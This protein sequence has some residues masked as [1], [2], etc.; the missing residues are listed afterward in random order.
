MLSIFKT[1]PLDE[2]FSVKKYQD[3]LSKTYKEI[4]LNEIE[5]NTKSYNQNLI[6]TERGNKRYTT[7]VSLTTVAFLISIVLL[8]ANQFIKMEKAPPKVQVVNINKLP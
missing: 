5:A 4:L 6:I 7:G 8:L 1:K 2:A 3:F